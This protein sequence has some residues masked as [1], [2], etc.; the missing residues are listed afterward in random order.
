MDNV[1]RPGDINIIDGGQGYINGAEVYIITNI[2]NPLNWFRGFIITDN[3]GTVK[4]IKFFKPWAEQGDTIPH[5]PA[6][7]NNGVI[8]GILFY[9]RG[10]FRKKFTCKYCN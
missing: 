7:Y 1:I 10:V 6:T 3:K 5:N 8:C 4:R 2:N 9:R